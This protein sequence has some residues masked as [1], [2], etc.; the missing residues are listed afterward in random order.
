MQNQ[1]SDLFRMNKL[2]GIFTG[3]AFLISLLGL[4][5]MSIYFIAQRKR[6]MAIRKVFGSS[7]LEE[8]KRLMKFSLHSIAISLAIAVPLMIVGIRSING[9]IEYESSFPWWVPIVAVL[10]VSL[11]SLASVYLISRKATRENPV[12]NLKTE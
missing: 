5:A 10:I 1:Y 4:T 12:E 2:I 8:Q 9:I 11:I 6:D 7:S 3:A